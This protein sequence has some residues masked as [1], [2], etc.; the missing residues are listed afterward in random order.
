V[1]VD[2][3]LEGFD[4]AFAE[5]LHGTIFE[6]DAEL[7]EMTSFVVDAAPELIVEKVNFFGD[8]NANAHARLRDGE[9][10]S[11]K[12]RR[13]ADLLRD[14][15]NALAGGFFDATPAVERAVHGADGD[16]RHFGDPMNSVFLLAH[17]PHSATRRETRACAF[18]RAATQDQML[19]T[20]QSPI[21][22]SSAGYPS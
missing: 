1:S 22:F 9:S 2:E 5:R 18:S 20:L 4:V 15:Q 3:L 17:L 11:G 21:S 19:I 12:I 16:V 6:L 14:L 7:L 10:A 8:A 13:I